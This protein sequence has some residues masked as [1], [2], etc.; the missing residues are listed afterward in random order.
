MAPL[1]ALQFDK[2][3][4]NDAKCFAAEMGTAGRVSHE[5]KTCKKYNYAEC[6]SY[7][8]ET[9]RDIALQWLIDHDVQ[10]LGHREICLDK[11]YT[12]IGVATHYHAKWGMCSVAEIIW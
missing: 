3:L 2:D 8:M 4:Y 12:K 1:P 7:G 11:A 6:C 5:R 10:S 9:G